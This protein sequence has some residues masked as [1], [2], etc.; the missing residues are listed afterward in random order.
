MSVAVVSSE[1]QRKYLLEQEAQCYTTHFLQ[2]NKT[3]GDTQ[4]PPTWDGVLCWPALDNGS[5]A[6][7]PC[8]SYVSG[9]N[10]AASAYKTCT[11]NGTWYVR[12]DLNET[13]TN[14]TLCMT[15]KNE[16]QYEQVP[17]IIAE[18]MPRIRLMYNIGYGI[19]LAS[20]IL[21]VTI[22][23]YFKRLHCPRNT[24]HINLF[25]SFTLRAIIS[26]V[27]ENALV[28]GVGFSIDVTQTQE[29]QTVF[30]EDSSHWQCKTFFSLFNYILCANYMWIFTEGI[31]L[32]MLITVA[33][34]SEKSGV[35]KLVIFGWGAPALFV[36]PWVIVRALLEDVLCWNTHPTNGYFWLIRG[37]IVAAMGINFII[38]LNIIRVLFT[39]LTAFN[40]PD[41]NRYRYSDGL[42]K[43]AKSTLVLIPLFGVH[44]I[45]FI[46]LPDN[47]DET[48]EL[49][50]LYYE[51]F[52]NS[53]QGFLVSL[54]F[55]FLNGEVQS[56]IRKK[57]YRF[58]L[59]RG[60]SLY[61]KRARDTMTSFISHHRASSASSDARDIPNGKLTIHKPEPKRLSN[62][63]LN[64]HACEAGNGDNENNSMVKITSKDTN[65]K[66]TALEERDPILNDSIS[67]DEIDIMSEDLV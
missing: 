11:S 28:N 37:P 59:R 63:G 21:A 17:A 67:D 31:Y 7:L 16:N 3:Y 47:V 24:I 60:G 15:E 9:F 32:H 44:Y 46:G 5:T 35:K 41:T 23:I 27:K 49:V 18:H 33:M 43:L 39:K 64:G 13:W 26:F 53:F 54:L 62:N 55:C 40:A 42:W 8:P 58:A 6:R 1:E 66:D 29:G 20:L 36:V 65:I 51:M 50:K 34:F 25:V 48:T 52:F 57:W 4:C 12:P 19:S 14:L 10:L 2:E 45:V 38:F 56:E 61:K 22:M 30:L